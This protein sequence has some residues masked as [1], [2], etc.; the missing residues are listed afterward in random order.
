MLVAICQVELSLFESNSLKDK[1]SI[2]LS[3]KERIRQRFNVSIAEIAELNNLKV[4]QFGLAIVSN[5]KRY[6]E[7]I[8]ANILNLIEDDGRVEII[9]QIFELG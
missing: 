3:L 6:L 4:A 1:R 9:N 2:V 5:E 8:Y 7:K